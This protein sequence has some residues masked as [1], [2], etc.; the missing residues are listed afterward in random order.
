[1]ENSFHDGQLYI[2]KSCFPF[3]RLQLQ[4]EPEPVYSLFLLNFTILSKK[5]YKHTG[6]Y[7]DNY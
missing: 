7:Q 6:T 5:T 3:S 4:L 1:M 2:D